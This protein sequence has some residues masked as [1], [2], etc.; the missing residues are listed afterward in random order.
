MAIKIFG[1]TFGSTKPNYDSPIAPDKMNTTI[2]IT[3]TIGGYISPTSTVMDLDNIARTEN[4]LIHKY[5]EI[6]FVPEVDRAVDEI[7]SEA[8]I[9]D[10]KKPSITLNLDNVSGISQSIKNKMIDEFTNIYN[11]LSFNTKGHDIFRRWYIDGRINYQTLIDND[12]P[13]NGIQELRYIDPRKIKRVRELIKKNDERT[14]TEIIVG[15]KEYFLYSDSGLDK[16]VTAQRTIILSAESVAHCNSGLYDPTSNIVI[17]HLHKAIRPANNLR[18]MEDSMIIYRLT[19]APEKR[20]FYIDTNGLS[21][22][23]GDQYVQEI[24]DKHRN[25]VIYDV[26][27]GEIRNDRRYMAMS[28]DYWIPRSDGS[29]SAIETLEGGQAVGET[30]EADYF[31]KELYEALSVPF[32]RMTEEQT[33]FTSGTDITRDELRFARYVNRLRIRFAGLFDELL[34]RQCVL[35]GILT[36]EEYEQVRSSIYYDFLE[37][38]YFSEAAEFSILQQKLTMVQMIDPFVGKYY[39]KEYVFKSIMGL[40]DEQ[41]DKELELIKSEQADDFEQQTQDMA[42]QSLV[43]QTVEP[44]ELQQGAQGRPANS[45]NR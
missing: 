37:D 16:N 41:M 15:V 4:E 3:S 10:K 28:E 23:K 2:D 31:K 40:T 29:S 42:Y 21:K 38:N 18:M 8:I 1:F 35:K 19:R 30:G 5:R 24:A 34:Q 14:N 9:N 6:V 20:V 13:K 11:L 7:A 44:P 25:K 45:Q 12:N 33:M 36:V 39:S 27:T 22:I 17:G 43:Q 26:K 32:A